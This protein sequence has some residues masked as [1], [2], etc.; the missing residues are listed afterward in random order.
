[1]EITHDDIR[2]S[3]I[4]SQHC[5]RNFD[6][7][8]T[9]PQEDLDLM[10]YAATNCPSKQNI[11]YY[12]VHVITNQEVISNIHNMTDGFTI[13]FEKNET[14]TNS[15]VLAN[16]LFVFERENYVQRTIEENNVQN[17]QTKHLIDNALNEADIYGFVRDCHMAVGIAA[18][19]VNMTASLLGYSTGCCACFDNVSIENYL[20]LEGSVELL[21]GIGYKNEHINRR[22]HPITGFM[23][24][25]KKKQPISVN[26][27]K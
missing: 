15:Q 2:K 12:K 20:K 26:V 5:Q 27:I 11:A 19:Y 17:V 9:I 21:M 22:V 23:F 3:I 13:N 18:G 14:T 4:K 24:P 8:K 25:S 7:S 1:M 10:I 6:L 16:A